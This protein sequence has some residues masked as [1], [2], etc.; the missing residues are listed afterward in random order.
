M[1]GDR[2]DMQQ[3]KQMVDLVRE[4]Q[5]VMDRLNRKVGVFDGP[6]YEFR[7]MCRQ[8]KI[9]VRES[10]SER[11]P[12]DPFHSWADLGLTVF[13]HRRRGRPMVLV[14]TPESIRAYIDTL[15]A[16]VPNDT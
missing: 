14:G 1:P 4:R 5:E 3:V 8:N 15:N 10:G 9:R 16:I 13:E 7:E 11:G 12:G 6:Y 2:F